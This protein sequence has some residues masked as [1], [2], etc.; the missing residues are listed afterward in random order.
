M[1][2]LSVDGYEKRNISWNSLPHVCRLPAQQP[3][4]PGGACHYLFI[5]KRFYKLPI[6]S[7]ARKIYRWALAIQVVMAW[8]QNETTFVE[9]IILNLNFL[10]VPLEVFLKLFTLYQRNISDLEYVCLDNISRFHAS[11]FFPLLSFIFKHHITGFSNILILS[12]F[13]FISN[14]FSFFSNIKIPRK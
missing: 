8:W 1:N 10:F 12:T 5:E 11:H 9:T 3:V 2:L 4:A 6:P 14:F 13:V 7:V